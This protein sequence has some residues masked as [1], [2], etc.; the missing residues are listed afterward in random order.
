MEVTKCDKCG[1]YVDKSPSDM[2]IIAYRYIA[3][4]MVVNN[5]TMKKLFV[6][7]AITS[8]LIG[9]EI[10]RRKV[11][12]EKHL[13]N[14]LSQEV[15][16][17][18]WH[19]AIQERRSKDFQEPDMKCVMNCEK[20][21]ECGG[22]KKKDCEFWDKVAEELKPTIKRALEETFE[23]AKCMNEFVKEESSECDN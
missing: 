5:P 20:F 7:N 14:R 19:D 18:P 12:D 15:A 13:F 21:M 3:N 17:H 9:L 6:T 22:L 4:D 11:M 1:A 2:P 16:K 23:P 10:I 8:F